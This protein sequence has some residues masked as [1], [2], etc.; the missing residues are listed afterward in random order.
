MADTALLLLLLSLL[1]PCA[2]EEDAVLPLFLLLPPREDVDLAE[3]EEAAAAEVEVEEEEDGGLRK[4]DILSGLF[5][6]VTACF[7]RDSGVTEPPNAYMAH[8]TRR[9]AIFRSDLFSMDYIRCVR[10]SVCVCV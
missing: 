8:S 3:E 1:A 7:F 5:G 9:L 2:T 6:F 4:I 10:A